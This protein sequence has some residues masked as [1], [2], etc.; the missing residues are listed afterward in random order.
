MV[1]MKE[2]TSGKKIFTATES[3]ITRKVIILNSLMPK[4]T[5]PSKVKVTIL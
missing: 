2:D 1:V 5:N 3:M 4:W